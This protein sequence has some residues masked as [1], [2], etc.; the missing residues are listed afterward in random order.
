MTILAAHWATNTAFTMGIIAIVVPFLLGW[1]GIYGL[2]FGL[3]GL[4]RTIKKAGEFT[5]KG[6]AIA[7]II[8]CTVALLLFLILWL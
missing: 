7:G 2:I 5:G 6:K 3:I 8:L 4:K 1:L